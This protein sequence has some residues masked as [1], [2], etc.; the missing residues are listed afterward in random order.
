MSLRFSGVLSCDFPR[1]RFS[2]GFANIKG[3]LNDDKW[4]WQ[5]C[6]QNLVK[7]LRWSFLQKQLRL[8]SVNYFR[9]KL[10]LRCL[11]RFRMGLCKACIYLPYTFRIKISFFSRISNAMTSP[12]CQVWLIRNTIFSSSWSWWWNLLKKQNNW[13]QKVC[14]IIEVLTKLAKWCN[15]KN[16]TM[17]TFQ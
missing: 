4:M 7:Y 10:H 2:C 9:K 11:I 3:I 1:R 14:I 15:I 5:E 8:K 12:F 6:I 16:E 17:L 13:Q